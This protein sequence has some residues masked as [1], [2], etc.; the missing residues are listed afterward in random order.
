MFGAANISFERKADVAVGVQMV[1]PGSD[2]WAG[3]AL[4]EGSAV[5]I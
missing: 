2:G 1:E 4:V 5:Q 3:R